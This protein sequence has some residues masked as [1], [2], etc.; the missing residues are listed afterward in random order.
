MVLVPLWHHQGNPMFHCCDTHV[1]SLAVVEVVAE[2]LH[3]GRSDGL[4][5][6]VVQPVRHRT[7]WCR[8]SSLSLALTT[9]VTLRRARLVPSSR[10]TVDTGGPSQIGPWTSIE[11]S[12]HACSPLLVDLGITVLGRELHQGLGCDK[13]VVASL[14]VG[15]QGSR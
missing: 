13:S 5:A 15:R 14:R 8:G 6:I 12:L 11:E 4:N 3:G 7:R 2:I 9:G 1:L 10:R